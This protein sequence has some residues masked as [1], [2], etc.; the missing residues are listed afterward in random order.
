MSLASVRST[1]GDS[2]EILIALKWAIQMLHDPDILRIA[3]DSTDLDTSGNPVQVDDVVIHHRSGHTTYCQCKKNQEDFKPWK[4]ADLADDLRKAA[5]QLM[6]DPQG[7]VFFYSA[8]E[9]GELASLKEHANAYSDADAYRHSLTQNQKQSTTSTALE[10]RW[11]DVLSGTGLVTYDLLR[12]MTFES[13]ASQPQLREE[14]L[15][16]LRQYVTCAEVVYEDLYSRLNHIKSRTSVESESTLP[17]SSLT[18]DA[19]LRLTHESGSVFTPP[20]SE[21]EL[22]QEFKTASSVGRSW[23]R[24]IGSK[25]LP[26]KALNEVLAHVQK[27]SKRIL[28]TDGPGSGK[29]CPATVIWTGSFS[30]TTR[31]LNVGSWAGPWPV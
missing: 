15:G 23:R 6:R 8:T 27:E 10:T 19:L 12:R 16:L 11:K 3:V 21:A 31:A 28:V 24:L 20:R 18:R 2:Y 1:R 25:A 5:R 22:L 7:R 14:L 29:T 26:R 30:P 17:A 4:V 13:T 9:F